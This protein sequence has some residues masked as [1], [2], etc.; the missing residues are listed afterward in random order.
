MAVVAVFGLYE[1]LLTFN[2]KILKIIKYNIK[3]NK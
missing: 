1:A 2:F 3:I